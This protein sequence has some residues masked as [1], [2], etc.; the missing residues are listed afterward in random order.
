MLQ[1]KTAVGYGA[2]GSLGAAVS[3]ALAMAGARVFLTGRNLAP[4]KKVADEIMAAGGE[5]SQRYLSMYFSFSHAR[6][7]ASYNFNATQANSIKK[8]NK[9][10]ATG[11]ICAGVGFL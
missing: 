3:K 7:G 8:K 9:P 1:N 2:G 11:T 4:V 10:M 5:N 6:T